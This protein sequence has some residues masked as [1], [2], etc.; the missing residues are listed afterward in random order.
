MFKLKKIKNRPGGRFSRKLPPWTPRKSFLLEGTRGL[1]P[2][3]RY[4][5]KITCNHASMHPCNTKT[6]GLMLELLREMSAMSGK[7]KDFINETK[8]KK[9]QKKL[10][11]KY[12]QI[13]H[14]IKKLGQDVFDEN[15]GFYKD[16]IDKV[17]NTEQVIKEFKEN[18]IK[19]ISVLVYLIDIIA[20]VEKIRMGWKTGNVK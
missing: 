8:D 16:T 13:S 3:L 5:I 17:K 2:L 11:G 15:D 14:Q 18:Q 6:E 7:L 12:F 1:A 9:E 4:R 10:L 19:L 20:D